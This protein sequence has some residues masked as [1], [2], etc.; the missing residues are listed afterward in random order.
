MLNSAFFMKW[1]LLEKLVEM[2]SLCCDDF[3]QYDMISAQMY[4]H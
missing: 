3:T 2:Q 1:G 4:D